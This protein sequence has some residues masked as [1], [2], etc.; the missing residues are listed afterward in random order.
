ML[1]REL[2]DPNEFAKVKD[3]IK[4]ELRSG[5]LQQELDLLE[6]SARN[7]LEREGKIKVNTALINRLVESYRS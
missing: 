1:K 2:P 7:Y 5:R 3:Q 4:E 6:D